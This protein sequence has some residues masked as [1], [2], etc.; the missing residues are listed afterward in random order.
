MVSTGLFA[1]QFLK[2][3]CMHM[4]D[5][6]YRVSCGAMQHRHHKSRRHHRERPQKLEAL[7]AMSGAYSMPIE[8]KPRKPPSRQDLDG[9]SDASDYL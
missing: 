7:A 3:P 5:A 6:I 2:R 1:L 4:E 8:E 9:D